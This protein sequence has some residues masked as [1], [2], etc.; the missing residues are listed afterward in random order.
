MEGERKLKA[1]CKYKSSSVFIPT[2][3]LE[4]GTGLLLLMKAKGSEKLKKKKKKT[5][6]PRI[7][8]SR[9][10]HVLSASNYE[11]LL[12][13]ALFLAP[14][15]QIGNRASGV[16]RSNSILVGG[17]RSSQGDGVD[18]THTGTKQSNGQDP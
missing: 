2:R 7:I 16:S 1:T 12:C 5:P 14:R 11:H 10:I 4:A 17:W 13:G 3:D 9:S 8:S 18:T 15:T 6:A